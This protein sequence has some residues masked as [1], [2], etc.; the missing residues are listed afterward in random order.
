MEFF[1]PQLDIFRVLMKDDKLEYFSDIKEAVKELDPNQKQFISEV[2]KV[3]VLL[4]VN[5]ATSATGKGHSPQK[6]G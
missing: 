2:I 6:D 5:P 4:Q 1:L 3:C